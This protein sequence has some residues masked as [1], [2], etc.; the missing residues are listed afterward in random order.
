MRTTMSL[1][2]FTALVRLKAA[3]IEEWAGVGLLNPEGD[4]RFDDLD[5]LRLMAIRH[6]EA[7][8]Y[9]P[10]RLAKAIASGEVEPFLGEYIYPR[11]PRLTIEQAAERSGIEEATLRELLVSLGWARSLL[12]EGRHAHDRGLQGH[13]GLGDAARGG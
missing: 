11:G 10:Q 1:Q 12:L 7:L 9:D 13:R 2:E 3:Q 5:L 8:G 4:E 6:Y